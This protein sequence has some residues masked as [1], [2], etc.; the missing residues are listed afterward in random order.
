M[1]NLLE[2]ERHNQREG[3]EKKAHQTEF[4]LRVAV[5]AWC[6]PGE[7]GE[8]AVTHGICP[9]HLREMTREIQKQSLRGVRPVS[10]SAGRPNK[11]K[12]TELLPVG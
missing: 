10:A 6:K 12:Q 2:F 3:S 1:K 4:F 8:A 9:R 5:C 7:G 11:F